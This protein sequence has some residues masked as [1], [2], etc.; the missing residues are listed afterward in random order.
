MMPIQSEESWVDS[1]ND[2][3]SQSEQVS[4]MILKLSKFGSAIQKV[5][6]VF[7]NFGVQ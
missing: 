3:G 4:R 5:L 7:Q 2:M 1:S 6:H